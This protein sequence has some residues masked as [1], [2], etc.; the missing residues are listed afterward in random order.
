MLDRVCLRDVATFTRGLTYTKADEVESSDNVVLRANNVDLVRGEL[1][2]SELR[3]LRR[4]LEIP[5]E[6]MLR[7]GSLLVCTASGSKSHLGKVA[8]IG[9]ELP[10]A[11]GGFMGLVTPT[12]RVDGRYL[13]WAMRSPAY[14]EFIAALSDGANIN[15]LKWA[16]LAR[17]EFYCPPLPEQNRI[18]AILDEAFE[19]IRIATANAE[20]NLANARELFERTVMESVFGDPDAKGW[21]MSLVAEL[22]AAAKGSIRTGPFGSQ[23]LHSEFVESGVAVLGIDN[24]VNNEFRWAKRRYISEEKYRELARY[25]VRPGDVIITIMG[26]CG[27]CAIVPDDIPVAINTKHLCCITLDRSKCLPEFLHAYFLYHP[28]A[29]SYLASQSKGAI[30]EGLNMGI[31]REMP[32]RYPPI[33]QQASI[34]GQIDDLKTGAGR[35]SA[36]YEERV[37]RLSDLKHSIL[38]HAFEGRLSAANELAA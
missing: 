6:K 27:R 11:F 13:Y 1:D 8:Y 14:N 37:A 24:A 22:A 32:V 23:L 4:E 3:Y 25:R 2:L 15:N 26:T 30:M 16:D 38:S 31:I 35:V 36:V 33:A 19:G 34:A 17:F 18:V 20:K 10:Y 7:Q 28:V 12:A 21:R 9:E 5:I 29:R